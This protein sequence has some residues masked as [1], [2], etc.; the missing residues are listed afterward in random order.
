MATK[1]A[2]GKAPKTAKKAPKAKAKPKAAPPRRKPAK[3]KDFDLDVEA[4][5]PAP[6]PQAEAVVVPQPP[7]PDEPAPEQPDHVLPAEEDEFLVKMADEDDL[8]DVLPIPA[9]DSVKADEAEA[10]EA[11][12]APRAATPLGVEMPSP[13][14]AGGFSLP[15]QF[16]LVA[17]REG[18][19][20]RMY[21]PR[22]GS[23]GGAIVGALL[24]ELALRG[25]LRVQRDRFVVANEPTNNRHLDAFAEEVRRVQQLSTQSAMG[26]LAR[27]LSKRIKPWVKNLEQRGI[28]R[29]RAWRHLGLFPRSELILVDEEIKAKL[30]NRLVRTLAGGGNP[31]GRTITLL[32]LIDAA[33]LL[34]EIVP[35]QAMAFNKK[36]IHGLVTGRDVLHYRVDPAMKRLQELAV[37]TVLKNVKDIQGTQ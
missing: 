23:Q 30:E 32:G 18:W 13:G 1:K 34:S 25:R 17:W 11:D 35:E 19:D 7:A 22:A 4:G 29:E 36:R 20:D 28:V 10:A 31:D 15:E 37:Q 27:G 9:P 8:D 5:M 6:V 26:H 3:R 14:E 21:K 2:A 12:D 24:L 33:G 16:L